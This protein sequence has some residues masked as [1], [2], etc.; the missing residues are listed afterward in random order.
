MPAQE[1]SDATFFNSVATNAS[2]IS[3]S[4]SNEHTD[5][6]DSQYSVDDDP[7]FDVVMGNLS[8]LLGTRNEIRSSLCSVFSKIALEDPQSPIVEWKGGMPQQDT[9]GGD[10][11]AC[12][13][14]ILS[15]LSLAKQILFWQ[16]SKSHN[17]S[18]MLEITQ[19]LA[20]LGRSRERIDV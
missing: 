16:W 13:T 17:D 18:S 12:N 7:P 11:T 19:A 6:S 14:D 5:N 20:R 2:D 3:V 9:A 1:R 15:L 8:D 4:S 10:S